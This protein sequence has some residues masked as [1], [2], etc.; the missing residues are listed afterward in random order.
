MAGVPGLMKA[1]PGP[2]PQGTGGGRDT[3]GAGKQRGQFEKDRQGRMQGSGGQRPPIYTPQDDGQRG[4]Y[5]G[6]ASKT[7]IL[8][9]AGRALPGSSA[10]HGMVPQY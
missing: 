1:S 5:V 4:G 6:R 8:S 3:P 10:V 9:P 2:A 7:P